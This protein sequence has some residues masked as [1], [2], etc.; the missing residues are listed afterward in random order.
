MCITIKIPILIIYNNYN[1][2]NY[3]YNCLGQIIIIFNKCLNYISL[4]F[5]LNFTKILFWTHIFINFGQTLFVNISN[6]N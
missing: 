4:N 1:Y 5:S 6:R 2:Y 3:D